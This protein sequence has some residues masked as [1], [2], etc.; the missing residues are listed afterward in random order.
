MEAVSR[1]DPRGDGEHDAEVPNATDGNVETYWTTSSY[2]FAAGGLGK[3]GVGIEL[4]ADR[5]PKA[6]VVQTD[7]PGFTA[8]LRSGGEVLS[9]RQR[10]GSAATFVLPSGSEATNLVLWITNRG[11]NAAVRVNEVT[12]R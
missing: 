2:R 4:E 7:T 8:E 11:D 12:A 3:P 6:V 5:P 9:P 1:V 10:V